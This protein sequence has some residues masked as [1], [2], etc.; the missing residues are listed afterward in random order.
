MSVEDKFTQ[1]KNLARLLTDAHLA[2]LASRFEPTIILG[3]G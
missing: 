3:R 2:L 1:L